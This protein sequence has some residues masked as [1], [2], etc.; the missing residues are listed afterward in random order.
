M[1]E[2]DMPPSTDFASA[3]QPGALRRLLALECVQDPGN[4]V[5]VAA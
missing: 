5:R 2:V 4:L 3:M 1:A